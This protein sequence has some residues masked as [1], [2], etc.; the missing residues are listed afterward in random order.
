MGVIKKIKTDISLLWNTLFFGLKSADNLLSQKD[1]SANGETEINI[2]VEK[3]SVLQDFVRGEETQR[4]KETRD[5]MYRV[6]KESENL[7]VSRTDVEGGTSL[8]VR[9]KTAADF[10]IKI[11]VF[12]PEKLPIRLVQ[13]NKFYEEGN[14]FSIEDLETALTKKYISIF[15]IKRDFI[16]RFKIEDYAKKLVVRNINNKEVFL[17]FYTSEYASQFG[18]IDALF[19]K[20]I[21]DIKQTNNKK[22]DITT[23]DTIQFITDKATGEN[24]LCQFEYNNIVFKEVNVFDGN[25]VITFKANVVVDGEYIGK[26]YETKEL[27]KKLEN[28]QKRD[29]VNAVDAETLLRHIKQVENNET[30]DYGSVIFKL[31]KE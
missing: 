29:S 10:A 11:D 3:D 4:V 31:D 26:K 8:K 18:K 25:F 24:S 30:P 13:D 1:S 22:S 5:E 16:P 2:G 17:D 7:T 6:L 27:N 20:Q 12:N 21:Y 28:K 23:F 19:V 15:T 14:S 9:K